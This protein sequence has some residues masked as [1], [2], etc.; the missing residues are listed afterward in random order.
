MI[1]IKKN[2]RLKASS[3]FIGN[4]TRNGV[5]FINSVKN[6]SISNATNIKNAAIVVSYGH[7]KIKYSS[8][9]VVPS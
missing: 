4:K 5:A 3:H 9:C 7:Q 2:Q 6:K 1:A 8:D